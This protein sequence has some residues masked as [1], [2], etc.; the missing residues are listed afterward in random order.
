LIPYGTLV[1]IL[2]RPGWMHYFVAPADNVTVEEAIDQVTVALRVAGLRPRAEH[3]RRR[4]AGAVLEA[5]I[6]PRCC[7]A[8]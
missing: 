2:L 3:L 6:T 5:S 8:S 1:H 7:S 4:D